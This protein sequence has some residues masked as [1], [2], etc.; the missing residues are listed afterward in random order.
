MLHAMKHS[1]LANVYPV[2]FYHIRKA[3]NDAKQ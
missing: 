2:A 3:T 1:L